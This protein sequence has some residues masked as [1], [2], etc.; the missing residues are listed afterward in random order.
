LS[1][2][3]E[4]INYFIVF[5]AGLAVVVIMLIALKGIIRWIF[6]IK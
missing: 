4:L 6:K 1:I 3:P 5:A 2:R